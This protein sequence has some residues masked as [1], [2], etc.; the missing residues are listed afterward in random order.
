MT[1]RRK[2]TGPQRQ[3]EAIGPTPERLAQIGR[4]CD[5]VT[6]A[7]AGGMLKRTGA[8][9][10]WS[11]LENLHRNN[12]ITTHQY[13][14]GEQYHRDWY[15]GFQASAQV[16]M[17]W[18]EHIS[19]MGGSATVLDAAERRAFH[20][21]RFAEANGLLDTIG[22]RKPI[23]WLCISDI[24]PRDVGHRLRGYRGR[25]QAKAAGATAIAIGLDVLA[26]FYGLIK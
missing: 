26:R 14:A 25:D 23:H 17:K 6:E 1:R 12:L 5:P 8:I 18:S 2:R 20:A 10:V 15:L 7:D 4:A 19:G 24:R 9:R 11:Q 21:R 3:A 16:T 22:L 13:D